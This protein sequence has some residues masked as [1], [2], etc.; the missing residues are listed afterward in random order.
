MQWKP[1]DCQAGSQPVKF[2]PTA[3]DPH[4]LWGATYKIVEPLIPRLLA[5]EWPV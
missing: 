4:K 2:R 1:G 5:G 3:S